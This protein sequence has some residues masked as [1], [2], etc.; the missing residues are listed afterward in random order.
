M[1]H[2]TATALT[3]QTPSLVALMYAAKVL[4][5]NGFPSGVVAVC[6]TARTRETFAG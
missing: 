6:V 5:L 1:A 2:R 3:R 4:L